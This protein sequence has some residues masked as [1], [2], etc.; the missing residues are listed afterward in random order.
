MALGG[1]AGAEP[2]CEGPTKGWEGEDW[3]HR[4]ELCDAKGRA[5]TPK[6]E[7]GRGGGEEDI[8]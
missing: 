6:G 1:R 4:P 5:R 3:L 8:K 2:A 7:D